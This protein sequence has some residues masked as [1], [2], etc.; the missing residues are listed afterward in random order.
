MKN[1][2]KQKGFSLI[3]LL[4]VVAIILI[5]AAIA[6]PNLLRARI[7]ANESSAA[8]SVRTT[9]TAEVSF[10]STYPIQGYSTGATGMSALGP[11][12]VTGCPAGGPLVTAAC[13]LD[14]N[15]SQATTTANAK[16]GYYFAVGSLSAAAP[17]ESYTIGGSAAGFNTTGVKGFCANEDG[18]VHY[19]AAWNAAPETA[20]GTCSSATWPQLGN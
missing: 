17:F 20:E 8:T 15:L 9:S 7:S 5:I 16:S 14:W 6:I 2:R 12:A 4:I 13:L 1:T 18:V 10:I 11:G 19:N 3:E